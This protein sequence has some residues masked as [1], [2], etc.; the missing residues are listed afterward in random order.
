M[1]KYH[2]IKKP[3]KKS[4]VIIKISYLNSSISVE[5]HQEYRRFPESC[6]NTSPWLW[7]K[8]HA[9]LQGTEVFLIRCNRTTDIHRYAQVYLWLLYGL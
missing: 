8:I 2:T 1:Y 7:A 6:V 9:F 4:L 3:Q 5:S